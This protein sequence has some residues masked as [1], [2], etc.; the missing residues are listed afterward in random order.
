M[1]GKMCHV[2][3]LDGI[4]YCE[5]NLNIPGLIDIWTMTA[6]DSGVGVHGQTLMWKHAERVERL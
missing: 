4:M 6:P 3:S 1:V 5:A 2:M